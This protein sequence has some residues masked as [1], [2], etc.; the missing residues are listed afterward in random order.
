M[1]K[2]LILSG[3]FFA[4]FAILLVL[5]LKVDVAPIGPNGT[6]I[7]LAEINKSVHE[8]FGVNDGL[9]TVTEYLGYACLVV[10]AGFAFG[11]L[12]QMIK[13]KSLLKVDKKILCLGGL[14]V[15]IGVIYVFFEKVIINYRPVIEKGASAPE[16]SF[17]SSHTV[18]AC[19]IMGSAIILLKDYVNNK[20]QRL[21][22]RSLCGFV[23]GAVV[24]GRFV[25]GVHWITD[26]IGGIL[27]S[28]ALIFAF[29]AVLEKIGK[30]EITKDT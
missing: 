20:P 2:K 25:C 24:I 23:I 28:L 5:V 9:Y 16:A 8:F 15:V 26:I 27:L 19:V 11:G 4:L 30:K 13:R 18:L 6:E 7:G 10:A 21:L 12:V 1:K 22:L 3:V 14:Y 17:P 29:C